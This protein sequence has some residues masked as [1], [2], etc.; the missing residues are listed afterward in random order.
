MMNELVLLL[1]AVPAIEA[2]G[3]SVY[4]IYSGQWFFIP[5]TVVVNF[6]AVLLFM[7]LLDMGKIPNR[8]ESF[9]QRRM[10]KAYR[11]I[12]KWFEKYGNVAILLLIALPSTGVGSFTGAFIG[13]AFGL[14]SRMFYASIFLGIALSLAISFPIAYLL[15]LV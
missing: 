10:D 2:R 12:E 5:L 15:N 6:L 4:F 14:K 8:L 13:R 3:A 11:R 1:S 9:M 7:K